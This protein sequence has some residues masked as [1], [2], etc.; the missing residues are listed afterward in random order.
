MSCDLAIVAGT[1]ALPE[2]LQAAAP[3][4]LVLHPDLSQPL[5]AVLH[6]L[7]AQIRETGCRRVVLAG[8]VPR[9]V[10]ADQAGDM[11]LS[12]R[13]SAA[14]TAAGL[15]LLGAHEVLPELTV[16]PGPLAGPPLSP[17]ARRD[18]LRGRAILEALASQDV[19]QAVVVAE[20][21]CLGIETVQ[22]TDSMLKYVAQNSDLY[23]KNQKGVLLKMPKPGQDLR[24][25]MPAIGPETVR[26]ALAAGLEAIVITAGTVLVLE[27]AETVKQAAKAGLC[28]HAEP[29]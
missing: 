23:E 25:D 16:P 8:K 9:P 28:L 26:L 4:A 10:C 7:I 6:D 13:V 20:G 29:L 1:G 5:E 18:M 17:Q 15:T 22:G 24:I 11:A 14:L 3:G 19:A 12:E 27:R 2:A 21:L